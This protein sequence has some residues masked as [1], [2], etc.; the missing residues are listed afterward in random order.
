MTMP[1]GFD[2]AGDYMVCPLPSCEHIIK[3]ERP[4]PGGVEEIA[5]KPGETFTDAINRVVRHRVE[6]HY[7]AN[8]AVINAHFE[9]EHTVVEFAVAYGQARNA[10]AEIH[11]LVNRGGEPS[12]LDTAIDQQCH[13][14]LGEQ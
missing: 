4:T 9:L 5:P 3:M 10:L 11:D 14:G 12:L 7:R 6:S 2:G 13:R 8:E 1:P